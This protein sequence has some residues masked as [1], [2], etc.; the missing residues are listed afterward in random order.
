MAN[1]FFSILLAGSDNGKTANPTLDHA[2]R[3]PDQML[4]VNNEQ[5]VI[6]AKAGI[7]EGIA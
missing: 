4:R 3:L 7:Q 1:A 6:P 5:S 2:S